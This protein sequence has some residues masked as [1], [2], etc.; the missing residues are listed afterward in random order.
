[1]IQPIDTSVWVIFNCALFFMIL[2]D[3]LL[4]HKNDKA[5]GIKEALVASAIW[6]SIAMTFNV[7]IYYFLGSEAALNFLTGYLIEQSLSID[8]LFVF[9]LIF[10]YFR[11]PAAY[12]YKVLFW[13]IFSAIIM[14]AVFIF[15][16]ISLVSHFHW[17][18]HVFG[19]FLIYSGIKMAMP[20]SSEV[21]PENNPLIGILKKIM[22]ITPKYH[23]AH[24]FIK[25][26][27]RWFATPL[28]VVLL[29]IES[30]DLIFAVDSI[31]A[32]MSI[33]LDPFIIYSSNMFAIIGLRSLYFSLSGAI[34]LFK[35]LNYGICTIL[36]FVGA[37]MLL[38]NFIHIPITWALAFIAITLITT[39]A[40]SLY[41]RHDHKQ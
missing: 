41:D 20:S 23:D 12:Q 27:H 3:L 9:L 10:K 24:F 17:I 33:T 8:N 26:N 18:L 4:V 13:G 6:V 38:S 30:S 40:A 2:V 22:P 14:R 32:V 21:H 36:V 16:G 5:V 29:C 34:N 37:K 25:E 39:I 35:Y 31:P 19:A 11:T 1:M 15:F 7:G 28:L